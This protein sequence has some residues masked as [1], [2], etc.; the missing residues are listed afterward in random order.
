MIILSE[1]Q[2]KVKTSTLIFFCVIEISFFYEN[3]QGT[4]NGILNSPKFIL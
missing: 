4:L 2:L 3:N 1:L